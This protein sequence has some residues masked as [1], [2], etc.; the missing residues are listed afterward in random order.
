MGAPRLIVGLGNFGWEYERTRHN[1]GFLAAERLVTIFNL[2]SP[3][4]FK[5]SQIVR[6]QVSGEKV[7]IAW[8]Q[9]FMNLSGQA[10]RELAAFYKTPGRDI[11]ILHDEIDL[12]LGRLKISFGGGLAGHK[13]LT[14]ILTLL[15]E[16][17]CRLKIGVGRPPAEKFSGSIADY[18]L[19]RFTDQEWA[20]M[21]ETLT[22]A[23]WAAAAWVKLGLASAQNQINRRDQEPEG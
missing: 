22:R 9:T 4:C 2:T 21:D 10:V 7:I 11:L 19:G 8:P 23:A 17:F 3:V 5:N 20:R 6:G 14:S 12:T 18:V 16:N 13:G 1:A 15:R